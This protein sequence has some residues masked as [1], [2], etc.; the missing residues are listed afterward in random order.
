MNMK[1][2]EVYGKRIECL[3]G[4]ILLI[5]PILGVAAFTISIFAGDTPGS[6]ARMAYLSDE[7]TALIS[8][9]SETSFDGLSNGIKGSA[10]AM[11]A[12]PIYLGLMAMVG[13]Y[14]VKN[15][16]QSFFMKGE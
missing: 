16:I 14:L 15:N 12:A 7:W 3:I 2:A 13:A 8:V 1:K 11:S 9:P 5:P 6:F 10:G 4:L